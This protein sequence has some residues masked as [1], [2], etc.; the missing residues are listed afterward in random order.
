MSG[1]LVM[2]AL[3]ESGVSPIR[4]ELSF[5]EAPCLLLALPGGAG[6]E[7]GDVHL[8][9]QASMPGLSADLLV[10]LGDAVEP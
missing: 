6:M 7:G 9:M 3:F 1:A 4:G 5:R 10:R 2:C 8:H